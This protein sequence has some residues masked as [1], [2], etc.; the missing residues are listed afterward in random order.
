MFGVGLLLWVGLW[1]WL[2]WWGVWSRDGLGWRWGELEVMGIR[3]NVE[4]R[5]ARFLE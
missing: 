1:V 5:Y 2:L 4:T 3:W